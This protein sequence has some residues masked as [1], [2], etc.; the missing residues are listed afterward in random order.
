MLG[1]DADALR[2]RIF[3]HRNARLHAALHRP[4][5]D[6]GLERREER[7]RGEERGGRAASDLD[8]L[9]IVEGGDGLDPRA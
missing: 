9:D 3:V 6:H 5:P 2:L 7:T 4:V 1:Y 8:A